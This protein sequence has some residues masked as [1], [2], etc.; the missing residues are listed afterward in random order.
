MQQR[1][2]HGVVCWLSA[3]A[4]KTRLVVIRRDFATRCNKTP[5]TF[6]QRHAAL[7]ER[8]LFES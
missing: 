8:A 1:Q 3:C 6:S 5:E 2:S 7:T 4:A